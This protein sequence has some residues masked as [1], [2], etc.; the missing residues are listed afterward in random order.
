MEATYRDFCDGSCPLRIVTL[1]PARCVGLRREV[2][3]DRCAARGL[4]PHSNWFPTQCCVAIEEG[5][6]WE[7]LVAIQWGD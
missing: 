3:S 2:V 1:G 5:M 6:Q 7:R 4:R